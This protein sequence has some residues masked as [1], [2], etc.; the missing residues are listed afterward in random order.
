MREGT[1]Q[2]FTAEAQQAL[3]TCAPNASAI[4]MDGVSRLGF[5]FQLRRPRSTFLDWSSYR[6][7][8]RPARSR[9]RPHPSPDPPHAR[10]CG[11]DACGRPF[12]LVIV[13]S[14]SCGCVQSSFEPFFFRLRSMRA[15][16]ARVG[17]SIPEAW[18]S[19]CQEVVIALARVAPHDA[20]QGGIRCQRRRVN[21][22]R[23]PFDQSRVGEALHIHVQTASWVSTSIN[24]RV[25]EIVEWS[26][27]ASGSTRP[28]NSRSATESAARHAIARSASRP[29]K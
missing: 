15:R 9:P 17:V 25:R 27:G 28:R 23:L 12:I 21:A 8:R 24:R 13:A 7:H 14:G 19:F 29:S 3:P 20:S 5:F 6:R 16:S 11:R 18:A 26:G 2:T 10:L 22:D 4:A 1:F